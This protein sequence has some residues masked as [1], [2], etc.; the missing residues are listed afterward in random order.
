VEGELDRAQCIL[1]ILRTGAPWADLPGRY[2][3]YQT[4]HPRFQ[5]WVR[6]GV[7]KDI[8]LVLA[9]A[10]YDAGRLDL[11]EAFID[12]TFAPAKRVGPAWERRNA[13]RAQK[14]W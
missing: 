7:V 12:G 8:L 13:A 6:G 4:C 3:P 5:H 10:L 9:E 11:R 1:W 14:L 2:P